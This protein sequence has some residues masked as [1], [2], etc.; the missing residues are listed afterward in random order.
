MPRTT[1]TT[2][3]NQPH[4][5]PHIIEPLPF[6]IPFIIVPL[7]CPRARTPA[8]SFHRFCPTDHFRTIRIAHPTQE[9]PAGYRQPTLIW[10][11]PPGPKGVSGRRICTVG[12]VLRTQ[13]VISEPDR[14]AQRYWAGIIMSCCSCIICSII[15]CIILMRC[16]INCI[17]EAMLG[18]VVTPP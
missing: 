6:M 10:V 17:C 18:S 3:S 5:I 8:R 15:C 9:L 1:S 12:D 2:T 4:P 11:A 7:A 14:L 16:C 13:G